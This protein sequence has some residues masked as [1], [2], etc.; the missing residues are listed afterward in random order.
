MTFADAIASTSADFGGTTFESVRDRL[1]AHIFNAAAAAASANGKL[2]LLTRPFSPQA[3]IVYV[4]DSPVAMAFVQKDKLELWKVTAD[5]VHSVAIENLESISRDI[6]IAPRTPLS[7]LGQYAIVQNG[8]GYAA[9][10]LLAPK[11]MARMSEELGA[12]FFA[13]A[14]SRNHLLAWSVDCSAR[15]QLAALAA[16]DAATGAYAITDELFVWSSDGIRLA[17][18]IELSQHGRG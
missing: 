12:E 5:D 9:A 15:A 4:I 10:G 18:P 3:R 7:G 6:P 17:N 2:T 13:T 16:K 8:G 14:P 1:R 11:F